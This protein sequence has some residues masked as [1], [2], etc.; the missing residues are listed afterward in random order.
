MPS[1]STAS[2][3]THTRDHQCAAVCR[4]AL[5]ALTATPPV[6]WLPSCTAHLGLCTSVT[7][8]LAGCGAGGTTSAS[9]SAPPVSWSAATQLATRLF[10][11]A[12]HRCTGCQ[13]SANVRVA[14]RLHDV[15]GAGHPRAP[16][17]ARPG[18]SGSRSAGAA[19]PV[20]ARAVTLYRA[21]HD[22]LASPLYEGVRAALQ[23]L[24]GAGLRLALATSKPQQ[25]A[26]LVV[27]GK[28]LTSFFD[29]V[30]GSDREGGRL[31]KGDVIASAL[32][33]LGTPTFPVMVGDRRHDVQ[34]AAEHGVP[35]IGVLWGYG[36][37][38]E[39]EQAGAAALAATPIELVDLLT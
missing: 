13:L 17:P 26:E 25:F 21:H 10:G 39:L 3:P 5:G 2:G 12:G 38:G 33:A 7:M 15:R 18:N 4:T 24:R 16:R 9:G 36:E 29:V 28:Q 1:T 37:P 30:V 35:C 19:D 27:A 32:V 11:A 14:R 6:F 23:A 22:Q 20:V 31:T 8:A 34:G